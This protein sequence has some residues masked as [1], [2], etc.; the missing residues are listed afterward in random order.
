MA[1]PRKSAKAEYV[2]PT[3]DA[4]KESAEALFSEELDGEAPVTPGSDADEGPSTA[5]GVRTKAVKMELLCKLTQD[6]L[7]R[8]GDE[9]ARTHEQLGRHNDHAKML[10]ADLKAKETRLEDSVAIIA[11]RIRTKSELREVDVECVTDYVVNAYYEVRRDTS[12]EIPG[13]RRSLSQD[14]RQQEL[15]LG[16]G[17][18]PPDISEEP[19]K[20]DD[21]RVRPLAQRAALRTVVDAAKASEENAPVSSGSYAEGGD[22]LSDDAPGEAF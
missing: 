8:A 21:H 5:P 14:E 6:E 1:R 20:D 18:R 19:Q 17:K 4:A 12:E 15:G 10:K 2:A 9:F 11:D 16:G 7:L 3:T 22:D 13:S